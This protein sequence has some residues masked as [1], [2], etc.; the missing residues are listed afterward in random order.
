MVWDLSSRM[1][2]ISILVIAGWCIGV[3]SFLRK[4]V[5]GSSFAGLLAVALI[6]LPLEV[7]SLSLSGYSGL[8]F[9]HYYLTALP[10]VSLLLAFLVWFIAKERLATP[11]SL[12][13]YC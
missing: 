10:V 11:R 5:Q 3:F 12:L 9:L 7:V 8:G 4:R 13:Q 6:S 2:P 1:D